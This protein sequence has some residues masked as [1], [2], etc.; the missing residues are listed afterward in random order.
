MHHLTS[1]HTTFEIIVEEILTCQKGQAEHLPQ[2]QPFR[3]F[4]AQARLGITKE[5][6]ETFFRNMLGDIDEPTAPF[7]LTNTLGDG[8]NI[9]ESNLRLNDT[10]AQRIRECAKVLGVSPASLFHLAWAQVLS[11]TSGRQNVVFGTVLF[12]RMQGGSGSD[13]MLG[14]FINTLPVR[15]DIND[16]SV[17]NSAKRVHSLLIELLAHEHASLALAQRCSGVASGM[18]LFTAL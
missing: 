17:Q 15:I 4:I 13:R 12:G 14:L 16:D 1:D 7:G 3:N 5:Q 10:L 8:T 18:P 9:L 6:H 2:P 11:I